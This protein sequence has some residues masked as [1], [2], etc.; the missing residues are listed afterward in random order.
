MSPSGVAEMIVPPAVRQT[1]SMSAVSPPASG[2][3]TNTVYPS[4]SMLAQI[5]PPPSMN[6]AN[7]SSTVVLPSVIEP[8]SQLMLSNTTVWILKS[9]RPITVNEGSELASRITPSCERRYIT[10]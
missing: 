9:P 4:T 5:D 8:I 1:E 3:A 2:S 7:T 6:I 10:R